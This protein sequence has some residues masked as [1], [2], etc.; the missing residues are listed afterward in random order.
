MGDITQNQ[1][2]IQQTHNVANKTVAEQ[3]DVENIASQLHSNN[4]HIMNKEEWTNKKKSKI[5][6]INREERQK[7]KNFM[8][9]NN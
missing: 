2:Q 3:V 9:R 1:Y 6:Q 5:V 8:K 4:V 7:G